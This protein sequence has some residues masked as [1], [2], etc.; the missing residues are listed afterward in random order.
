MRRY[1]SVT[2]HLHTLLAVKK[3]K[4]EHKF[5]KKYKRGVVVPVE[6]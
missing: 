3:K 4:D 2:V 6:K 1:C 5:A